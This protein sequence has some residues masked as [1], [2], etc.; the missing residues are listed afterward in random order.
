MPGSQPQLLVAVTSVRPISALQP[1][2]AA[3][4]DKVF[5]AALSEAQRSGQ[6]MAASAR[7]FLLNR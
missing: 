3:A 1:S 2:G 7:Y 5:P 6:P 4:A